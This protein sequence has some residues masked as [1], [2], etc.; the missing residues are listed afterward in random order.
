MAQSYPSMPVLV[1]DDEKEILESVSRSLAFAG[2]SNVALCQDS[3]EVGDLLERQAFSA[4]T[5]DLTMPH[6]SGTDLL[7]VILQKQPETPVIIVTAALELD[8]AVGC[9]KAGA[10]DY[11]VKP[12]DITRLQTCVQNAVKNW[13]MKQE[14][15][16]LR[17]HMLMGKL[18]HPQAFADIVTQ[19]DAMRSIF[20]YI[21]AIGKTQ[22]S[23]LLTGDTGVGKESLAKAIHTVSRRSGR[24]V[25]TNVAGLDDSMFSDA[26][27][28]HIKGAF[29]GATTNRDGAIEK[30]SDG[31]LFLDEIGDL[32]SESQIKLLRLLQEGEYYP[33]GSDQVRSSSARFVFATNHH[34]EKDVEAGSFRT[35]LYFRLRSHQV[36]VP[37]LKDRKEDIP[38]LADHFLEQAARE[39]GKKKPTAPKELYLLLKQYSFPGNIRELRGLIYDAVVRHTS[40]SMSLEHFNRVLG[41]K[42]IDSAALGIRDAEAAAD[43]GNV[44]RSLVAL[45]TTG[46]AVQMLVDEALRRT[47]GNQS[48]AAKMI[49]ISRVTLNKRLQKRRP[50]TRADE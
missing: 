21:E 9:M 47:E 15:S 6:V 11:L 39:I 1:V 44:Y 26:M 16:L 41:R 38:P 5:L 24:F 23:V 8:T 49:G 18:E 48:L 50:K 7:P 29:T 33:L 4:V 32:S 17:Q 43:G 30:A 45:P 14:L 34:I 13:E 31:T 42:A 2:I 3:R 22:L 20:T 40:G 10:F 37:A 12:V 46:E 35:D 36:H 25:A 28:G 19:S 27:F